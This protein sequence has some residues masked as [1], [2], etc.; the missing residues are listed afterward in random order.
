MD[1]TGLP[2]QPARPR[3]NRRNAAIRGLARESRLHP[4]QL[5]YPLFCVDGSGIEEPIVTAT[6]HGA[7]ERGQVARGD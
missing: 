7:L 3:R 5:I 2:F 1:S 6:R 4:E